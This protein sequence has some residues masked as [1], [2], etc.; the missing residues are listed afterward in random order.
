MIINEL[1]FRFNK[2]LMLLFWTKSPFGQF[3]QVWYV[4]K[5]RYYVILLLH[6]ITWPF[7]WQAKR[8][9]APLPSPLAYL[10]D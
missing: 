3:F 8:H 4:E 10:E 6:L 9:I 7:L 1:N 5:D 2:M